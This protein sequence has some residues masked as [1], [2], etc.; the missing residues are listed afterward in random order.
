MLSYFQTAPMRNPVAQ[1]KI[2]IGNDGT[3]FYQSKAVN[4]NH[5]GNFRIFKYPL[6]FLA[7]VTQHIP[8]RNFQMVRY[9]GYYSNASIIV[10]DNKNRQKRV[11]IILYAILKTL[12]MDCY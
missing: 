12:I 2:T 3:I 8:P 1:S 10:G 7:E 4:P 9:Y 6:E 5:K 11:I